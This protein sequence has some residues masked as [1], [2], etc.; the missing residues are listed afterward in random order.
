MNEKKGLKKFFF[1]IVALFIC[2]MI[3]I[4]ALFVAL[5]LFVF[6]GEY[7]GTVGEWIYGL[8]IIFVIGKFLRKISRFFANIFRFMH[9]R[10]L[11]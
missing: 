4:V 3:S 2:V 5:L 6:I 8:L 1:D 11:D 10:Y 9:E 7:M